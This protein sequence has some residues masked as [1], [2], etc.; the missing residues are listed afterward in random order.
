MQWELDTPK[1]LK[2]LVELDQS[3]GQ[4]KLANGINNIKDL[5]TG[6]HRL[7][8]RAKDTSGALG[9]ASGIASG[10][11][12][13]FVPA[14]EE[15]PGIVKGLNLLT[16]LAAEDVNNLYDK[17]ES[18]RIES[19]KQ[20]V[21]ILKT[22]KVEEENR[23]SFLGKLEEGSLA[24]LSSEVADK[25]MVLIDAS[26]NE[27]ALLMD[28]AIG[29]AETAVIAAST[30]VLNSR[31]IIDTPLGEIEFTIDTQG[32]D[33]SV[34]QL[35]MEDGGI[36]MDT[37]FK[38]DE[39]G[40]PL[41]FQSEIISYSEEDGP[42]EDWLSSL[43]YGIYNYSLNN[44]D[45]NESITTIN[46]DDSSL[47]ANILTADPLFDFNQLE[48][49]DGSAFLIDLDQNNT[50]DLINMLLVDQGWF[51]TRPDVVGLIGDPLIPVSTVA[52]VALV[53][54]GGGG[55]DSNP[56]ESPTD[57][58]GTTPEEPEDID[59]PNEEEVNT[60]DESNQPD[61]EDTDNPLEAVNP[62]A[63]NDQTNIGSPTLNF[64]DG[65]KPGSQPEI[66][67]SRERP[68]PN[69]M[70]NIVAEPSP[71][72]N[73]GQNGQYGGSLPS[74]NEEK[75]GKARNEI[76][77]SSNQG[78]TNTLNQLL[79]NAQNWLSAAQQQTSEA[80]RSIIAPLATA[81]DTSIAAALGMITLPILTERSTTRLLK[82]ANKDLNLKLA[83]RDPLFN[84]CW[85][86]YNRNGK[87]ILIKR[88]NGKISLEPYH[89]NS[90]ES[91]QPRGFNPAGDALL[92]Q[93]LKLCRKPG[94]FIRSL[95]ALQMELT[96]T[97]TTDINW[98]SWFD[99][100][101]KNNNAS[102][103]KQRDAAAALDQ[104]RLYIEK[105]TEYEPAFADVLML[106][107]LIDCQ[108]MLG[109]ETKID[110]EDSEANEILDYSD[111]LTRDE[112]PSEDS[113]NTT[114]A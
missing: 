7:I 105:A 89:P 26:R 61:R 86:T 101:F 38:T 111:A 80:L 93:S 69:D 24:V 67:Q 88:K 56:E 81:E 37:L 22:L 27:G 13:L 49:I 2:G 20:V 64:D 6:S 63:D 109:L 51:D 75:S 59:P 90:N 14:A 70:P 32:R 1:A 31:E 8:V 15:S 82:A 85:V 73:N 113:E 110:E 35:Q 46:R 77:N 10:S 53:G 29:E 72:T 41:V 78:V 21:Q 19:E 97:Q 66:A 23:A 58:I 60:P 107:Q 108:E 92:S 16:Q 79:N 54:G 74:L 45:S 62:G 9:D 33:F 57:E 76:A 42:L 5:P 106:R 47:A 40:N 71:S 25:P 34:V 112:T 65:P 83:R 104:L 98:N 114:A 100:H 30:Q 4:I 55:T 44:S 50:I 94:A 36:N 18:D 3:T 52:T 43:T 48:T 68:R 39:D 12:R 11:V 102:R 99:H 84:G 17:K 95:Q 91:Q 28:A 96:H 87:A 103:S